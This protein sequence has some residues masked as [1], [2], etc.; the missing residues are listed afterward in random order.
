MNRYAHEFINQFIYKISYFFFCQVAAVLEALCDVNFAKLD[1]RAH[2][3]LA[4]L[5]LAHARRSADVAVALANR[6]P[7]YEELA[8]PFPGGGSMWEKDLV[9]AARMQ[10]TPNSKTIIPRVLPNM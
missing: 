4:A 9:G 1:M 8:R 6:L 5:S 7:R 3:Q 2:R 10:V